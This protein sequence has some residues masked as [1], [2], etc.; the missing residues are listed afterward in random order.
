[1]EKGLGEKLDP[2]R[3]I[4]EPHHRALHQRWSP[5]VTPVGGRGGCAMLV[6]VTHIWGFAG[7]C[8]HGWHHPRCGTRLWGPCKGQSRPRGGTSPSPGTAC[9]A[10]HISLVTPVSCPL[11]TET[12][13]IRA[14]HSPPGRCWAEVGPVFV[15]LPALSP[16]QD[17]AGCPCAQGGVEEPSARGHRPGWQRCQCCE[18]LGAGCSMWDTAS[19]PRPTGKP[20]R[21][22]GCH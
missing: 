2:L 21:A 8:G 17:T 16:P 1:M 19:P 4:P 20:P 14:R 13:Q 7:C 9:A 6:A 10:C 3:S 18:K 15:S 11:G 5:L 22:A 12:Q